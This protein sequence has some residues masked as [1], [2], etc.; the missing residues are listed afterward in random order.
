VTGRWLAL[1]V[2]ALLGACATGAAVTSSTAETRCQT[3]GG[4]WRS[5]LGMCERPG[6][7]GGGGGAGGM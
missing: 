5:A 1:G 3:D 2:A 6:G 4:V 7:G